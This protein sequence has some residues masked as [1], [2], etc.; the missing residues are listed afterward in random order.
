MVV[1][2]DDQFVCWLEK[3]KDGYTAEYIVTRRSHTFVSLLE[4]KEFIESNYNST[5]QGGIYEYRS[6]K[7]A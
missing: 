7:T 6:Q 4:A 1:S 3:N 2:D 5:T